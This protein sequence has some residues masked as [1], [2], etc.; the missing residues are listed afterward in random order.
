MGGSSDASKGGGGGHRPPL[1]RLHG[2]DIYEQPGSARSS[3]EFHRQQTTD[4]IVR[5]L[6]SGARS[7]LLVKSDGTIVQGNTR[8]KVLEERGYPID[9]LWDGSVVDDS[10]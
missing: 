5:S 1:R 4:E 9:E 7:P 6:R 3:L 10:A 8:I 2:D